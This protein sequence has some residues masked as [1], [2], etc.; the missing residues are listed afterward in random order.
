LMLQYEQLF[1]PGAENWA[2]SAAGIFSIR[3]LSEESLNRPHARQENLLKYR[4][5]HKVAT[6]H[7]IGAPIQGPSNVKHQ[8]ARR[9]LGLN[10]YS[11]TKDKAPSMTHLIA[12]VSSTSSDCV[13]PQLA[14]PV[15]YPRHGNRPGP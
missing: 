3:G 1:G 6:L 11:R 14:Q 2:P 4:C 15:C 7:K 9:P 10:Q 13:R 5:L 12:S 8:A